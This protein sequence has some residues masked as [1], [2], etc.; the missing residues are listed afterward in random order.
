MGVDPSVRAQS[1]TGETMHENAELA[2]AIRRTAY[3]LWQQEGQP[4][5]RALDHW[6]GAKHMH[7]RQMAYDRWLAEGTPVDRAEA[8]WNAAAGR[9]DES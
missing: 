5:G 7:Q 8:H 6:L 1:G 4:H 9:I 3:F 2:E